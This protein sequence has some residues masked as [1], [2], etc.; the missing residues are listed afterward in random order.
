MTGVFI[1]IKNIRK[2]GIELLMSVW[3]TFIAVYLCLR[4]FWIQ[5]SLCSVFDPNTPLFPVITHVICTMQEYWVFSCIVP[6]IYFWLLCALGRVSLV[7]LR[8]RYVL[9]RTWFIVLLQQLKLWFAQYTIYKYFF[10]KKNGVEIIDTY[11]AVKEF[12]CLSWCMP[13][14]QNQKSGLPVRECSCPGRQLYLFSTL[15]IWRR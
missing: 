12:F 5:T 8:M 2:K 11:C 9:L 1:I 7:A 3:I 6:L 13:P 4:F 10:I 14:I 15:E